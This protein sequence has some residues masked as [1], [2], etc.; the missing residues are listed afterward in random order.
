ME[1]SS[2]AAN[3]NILLAWLV[4]GPLIKKTMTELVEVRGTRRRWRQITRHRVLPLVDEYSMDGMY[5]DQDQASGSCPPQQF[6]VIPHQYRKAATFS[7]ASGDDAQD[8]LRKY[9]RVERYNQGSN[10]TKLNAPFYHRSKLSPGSRIT[11]HSS[12]LRTT[13]SQSYLPFSG[14]GK[15]EKKVLAQHS[16]CERAQQ[17]NAT[18]SVYPRRIAPLH[19]CRTLDE[20]TR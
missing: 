14:A 4:P 7:G 6:F 17:L 11:E 13:S 18:C 20:Q 15:T 8:W 3:G 9:S 10:Q 5:Q 12:P 16:P 1:D 2:R 19:H